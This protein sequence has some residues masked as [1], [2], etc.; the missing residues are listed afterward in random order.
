MLKFLIGLVVV[1]AVVVGGYYYVFMA[2]AEV[3]EAQEQRGVS[4]ELEVS[5]KKIPAGAV[6]EDGT[7]PE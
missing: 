5:A 1:L 6:M 4:T 3:E 7:L 2:D